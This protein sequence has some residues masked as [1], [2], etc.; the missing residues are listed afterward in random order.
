MRGGN[1]IQQH[2]E[3]QLSELQTNYNLFDCHCVPDGSVR[4]R[5]VVAIKYSNMEFSTFESNS[6]FGFRKR[7]QSKSR[8]CI[9]LMKIKAGMLISKM[10]TDSSSFERRVGQTI[11]T[12]HVEV[13]KVVDRQ[14]HFCFSKQASQFI[15]QKKKFPR[16]LHSV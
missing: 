4:P 8:E 14:T 2:F 10:R 5:C 6:T 9:F 12:T 3:I 13:N 1:Q 15:K 16:T 11:L 7:V